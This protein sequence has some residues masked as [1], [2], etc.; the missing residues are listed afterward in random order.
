MPGRQFSRFEMAEIPH[1]HQ[2]GK[3][4]SQDGGQSCA[5]HSHIQSKNENRI[6]YGIDHGTGQ[7]AEHRISGTSVC[8]HQM[9]TAVGKNNEREADGRNPHIFYGISQH[10]FRR[11]KKHQHRLQENL[12]HQA[13]N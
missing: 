1:H 11:T 3:N 9:G 8:P 12:R 2:S 10:L 13:E 4:L 5:G 7:I 6:Q